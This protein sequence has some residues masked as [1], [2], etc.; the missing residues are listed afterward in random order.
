[1]KI[2]DWLKGKRYYVAINEKK[3]LSSWSHL[4]E[5]RSS[6]KLAMEDPYWKKRH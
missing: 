6:A 4:C 3:A 2:P 1:M 5:A